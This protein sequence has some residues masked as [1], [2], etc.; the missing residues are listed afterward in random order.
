MRLVTSFGILAIF[1]WSPTNGETILGDILGSAVNIAAGVV[2]TVPK[3]LEPKQIF[4]LGKQ[5]LLGYPIELIANAI[6]IICEYLFP[7]NLNLAAR[8]YYRLCGPE[9]G[10]DKVSNNS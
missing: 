9:H 4:D 2:K 3:Y 1:L 10:L 8:F 7:N 6:N 5:S